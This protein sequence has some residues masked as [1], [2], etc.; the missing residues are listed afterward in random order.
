MRYL[1]CL[2]VVFAASAQPLPM[3][4]IIVD[5][6]SRTIRP[7]VADGE[8]AS[9]GRARVRE[10]DAAWPAPDGR[11]VLV[12]R[13]RALHLVRRLDGAIPVWREFREDGPAVARAAWSEDSTTIALY[14]PDER[15]IEFWKNCLVEPR[16]AYVADISPVTERVVSLA[17]APEARVA[18][19]AT[20]GRESGTLWILEEGFQP[21]MLMP[22]GKAGEIRY[23][24]GAL[25][26]ADRGRNEVLRY[27]GWQAMP[28]VETL[29]AAG[30]GLADPV[31]FALLA[32]Q[33]KLLVASAG[34][35]QLLV[36]D[37]RT[38]RLEEPVTLEE[39]P[40]RLER[41]GAAPLFALDGSPR[42]AP[43]LL[44]DA[45]AQRLLALAAPAA[46]G[47]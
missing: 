12:A 40:A 22:L 27:T 33:K 16:R 6:V 47:E 4:G 37:L 36:L 42:T 35:S 11:T 39:P 28:R 9:T 7:V 14:L 45:A 24:G 34:T 18:F 19:L 29:V 3:A 8:G 46:A 41:I 21:R 31:G 26:I 38:G 44:Y 32:D 17:L 43:A 13:S 1:S 25:Y 2:F 15:K 30:H 5:H 23:I 10:F 20:Q